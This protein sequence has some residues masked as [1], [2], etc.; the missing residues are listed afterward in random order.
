MT[1]TRLPIDANAAI[2]QLEGGDLLINL[3][4]D[5]DVITE[6]EIVNGQGASLNLHPADLGDLLAA[7]LA[8]EALAA[9]GLTHLASQAAQFRGALCAG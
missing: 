6:V 1:I 5:F 8:P 7:L 2:L 3:A 9:A 4:E